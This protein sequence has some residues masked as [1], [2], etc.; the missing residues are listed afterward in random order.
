M[1]YHM[2][3]M[4]KAIEDEATIRKVLNT[5]QYITVAMSKDDQPYLV[6][7][8]HLYDEGRNCIYFHSASE[9]KKL[10]YMRTNSNVWGQALV[11]RGYH[12]GECSHLY[13]TV[14]FSGKVTFVDDPD[15]KWHAF[16]SMTRKMDSD[17]ERLIGSMSR[18]NVIN[19]MVVRIDID[20]MTGKKSQ[21]IE[22]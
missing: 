4:D 16:S 7:L 22:V 8:S 10:D 21:E 9:G 15:E 6:S 5:A 19:T 17:P 18:E 12:E 14:M 11:D 2:R 20:Y 1:R 3:R 13:A